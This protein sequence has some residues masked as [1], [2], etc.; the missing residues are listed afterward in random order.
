MERIRVQE[1][2]LKDIY[3]QYLLSKN[4]HHT[5]V[6]YKD[7]SWYHSSAA[8]LCARKHFFS[9]VSQVEG[10]P[11]GEN[12]QRIFRLG[13]LVHEDIQDAL[14]WYSQ[15]HGLPLLIEKEIYLEDLNVRGYIDLALI[16][17][18]GDDHIIYDIKTCNEWKWKSLFG[19]FGDGAPSANYQLQLA[20]YG[21]WAKRYYE[22]DNIRMKLCYYNKNTSMMKEI[23][24][25][26]EYIQEAYE[27]WNRVNLLVADKTPPEVDLGTSPVYKWECNEKYCQFY[28]VCGGG[29]NAK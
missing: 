8:G 28:G 12:T 17:T 4:E 22:L 7:K 2:N 5:A 1:R 23:D 25:S 18:E 19:K 29:L 26:E 11:V 9:S 27:Y 15:I 14:T 20:T 6:R 21:L 10:T 3:N 24:V 13:N 16:D